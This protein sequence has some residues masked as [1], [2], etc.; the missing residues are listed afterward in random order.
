M[1]AFNKS[2]D[3]YFVCTLL[4]SSVS[5]TEVVLTDDPDSEMCLLTWR[6]P[7][8]ADHH[9]LTEYFVASQEENSTWIK[10]LLQE[11]N[12]YLCILISF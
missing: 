11:S 3:V 5:A 8:H 9:K 4:N 10:L 6:K 1:M 2:P 12:F 7:Q